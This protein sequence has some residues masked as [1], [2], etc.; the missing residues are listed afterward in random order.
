MT[1]PK[2]S[3]FEFFNSH[4][5]L[6]SADALTPTNEASFPNESSVKSFSSDSSTFAAARLP[7]MSF[8]NYVH[9]SLTKISSRSKKL[10]FFFSLKHFM[11]NMERRGPDAV[12]RTPRHW[13]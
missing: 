13:D 9:L 12:K 4:L 5:R 1:S 7:N 8:V 10:F 3:N 6:N 2:I 11:F